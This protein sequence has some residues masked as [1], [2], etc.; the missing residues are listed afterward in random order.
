MASRAV[1]APAQRPQAGRSRSFALAA[2]A[3]LTERAS[4]RVFKWVADRIGAEALVAVVVI[5]L[6]AAISGV[7]YIGIPAACIVLFVAW[8]RRAHVR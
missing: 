5:A 1:I 6:I 2:T 3:S 8:R 4:A 7:W